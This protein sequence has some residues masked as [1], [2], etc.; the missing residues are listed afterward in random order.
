MLNLTTLTVANLGDVVYNVGPVLG[1]CSICL[2]G[3]GALKVLHGSTA[4]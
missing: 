2:I 1:S 4:S 3:N